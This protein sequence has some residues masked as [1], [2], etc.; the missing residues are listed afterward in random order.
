MKQK[1][2]DTSC[3]I[4][5]K[6]GNSKDYNSI[7]EAS[8][9][10]GLTVASI[11]I[12]C[13][14]GSSGK[15]KHTCCWLNEHTKRHYLAK[16]SKNKGNRFELEVVNALKNIGYTG[17]MTSRRESK[18]LDDSKIDIFDE[19]N[20]LPTHIQCKYLLNTPNYFGIK[21]ECPHKDKPFTVVWKKATNDG[22]NSPGS[23]AIVDLDFFYELLSCYKKVNE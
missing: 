5:D 14:S 2:L 15:D 19:E 1:N 12:R 21:K 23:V 17:C 18:K 22:T 7:E 9:D 8:K 11:K 6:Y 13:N 4:T 20:K 16:K 10:S 3:R